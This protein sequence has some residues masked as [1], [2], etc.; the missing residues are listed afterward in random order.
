MST[1]GWIHT[2]FGIVALLAGTAV[3]LDVRPF[4]DYE[5]LHAA[6]AISIPLTELPDRFPELSQDTEI[7]TYCT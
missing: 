6:N 5:T 1:L 7:L 4:E 3:I 2:I